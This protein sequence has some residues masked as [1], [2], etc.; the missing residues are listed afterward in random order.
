MAKHQ[1]AMNTSFNI[2]AA[3]RSS[4]P[5]HVAE[6]PGLMSGTEVFAARV[7]ADDGGRVVEHRDLAV[8]A[9]VGRATRRNGMTGMKVATSPPAARRGSDKAAARQK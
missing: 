2:A 5:L 3:G 4:R 6:A 1:S 9:Q 7:A 8:A